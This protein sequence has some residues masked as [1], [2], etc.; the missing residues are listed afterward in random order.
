MMKVK[1]FFE[2]FGISLSEQKFEI[3]LNKE[4]I[5]CGYISSIPAEKKESVLNAEIA[6]FYDTTSNTILFDAE[7]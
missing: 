4:F 6:R 5:C 7:I 2:M 3:Y 1:E